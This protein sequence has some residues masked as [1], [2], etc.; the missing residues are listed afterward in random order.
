DLVFSNRPAAAALPASIPATD[1][2]LGV[3]ERNPVFVGIF[4]LALSLI[5]MGVGYLKANISSIVGQLYEQGDPRRDP[6]FTLYYFGINLG[7]FL[8]SIFCGALAAQFGW[9]AGFGLAGV[10]MFV[11]WLVFVRRRL[12]F[13][14][15]GE[16][17]LPD[18]IGAPPVPENLKKKV[19]GPISM[20]TCLYA[21]GLF[22]G[23][24]VWWIIQRPEVTGAMLLVGL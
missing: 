10:G 2:V 16:P 6:G 17:Q 24:V 5:V 18:E 14:I 22:G 1:Y 11:G 9:W 13:F 7:A 20:E 12:L 15:P 8:A 4:Y 19:F 3:S 23:G 21:I